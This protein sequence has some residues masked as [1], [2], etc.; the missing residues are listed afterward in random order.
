MNK[1]FT[2]IKVLIWDIDGT[3]YKPNPRMWKAI[4]EASF[5]VIIS[6][7]NWPRRKTIAEF[8]QVYP[9]QTTS[10]TAAVALITQ[11]PVAQVAR[12]AETYKDRSRFLKPDP[13]LVRLFEQLVNFKHYLLVNGIQAVTK[14]TLT[15]LGLNEK[16]FQEIITSEIVGVNKPDSKGFEYILNKTHLP[17]EQHLMIGD[18]EKVDLLP[19]KKLGMK[20]CLVWSKKSSEIADA[21]LTNIYEV[22]KLLLK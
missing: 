15:I 3:L 5:Q 8:N 21:A 18:R 12:E 4:F 1:L 17:P 19:A 13:R 20:T 11:L 14:K 6:H 9:S 7:T 2:N 10:Q 22:A 16:I